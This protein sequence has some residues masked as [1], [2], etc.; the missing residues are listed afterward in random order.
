MQ[1]KTGAPSVQPL[2]WRS[3]WQS[4]G[5]RDDSGAEKRF[6]LIR[7][8]PQGAWSATEWRWSPSPREATKAWQEKRWNALA[9]SVAQHTQTPTA[10]GASETRLMHDVLESNLGT[11]PAERIAD[12]LTWQTDGHC[13]KADLTSPGPQQLQ[14]S[15]SAEDSRLEQRAAMQLQLAR[16]TPKASWLSPFNLVPASR[17]ARGGAKFYAVW[18]EGN[19]MKGQLWIPTRGNGPLMRV[20]IASE[21]ASVPVDLAKNPALQRSRQVIERELFALAERWASAYE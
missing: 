5:M 14:L 8:L 13:L 17:Q 10:A 18:I 1:A 4:Q 11:R 7:R 21:L 3:A 20:R 2:V 6:V 9:A 15:Y 16:R 19:V 12:V